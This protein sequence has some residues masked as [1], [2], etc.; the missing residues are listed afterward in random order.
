[1]KNAC[2]VASGLPSISGHESLVTAVLV[3]VIC[4][5]PRT[6]LRK[7]STIV[8][9][10]SVYFITVFTHDPLHCWKYA[11]KTV[12]FNTQYSAPSL[13]LVQWPSGLITCEIIQ[14]LANVSWIFSTRVYFQQSFATF[15]PN[16]R[17]IR[18][19]TKHR[20]TNWSINW[21]LLRVMDAVKETIA[22]V[23]SVD[24]SSERFV[25]PKG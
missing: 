23:S 9:V 24:P 15:T 16:M 20:Y 22:G 8:H 18:L 5:V 14:S 10:T 11:S 17:R 4:L 21:V 1:M 12:T 6:N 25:R 7:V 19:R 2:S 3:Q 13:L